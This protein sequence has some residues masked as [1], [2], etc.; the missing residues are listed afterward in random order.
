MNVDMA[1]KH[2]NDLY[3]VKNAN[4]SSSVKHGPCIKLDRQLIDQ[5]LNGGGIVFS[6]SSYTVGIKGPSF[7]LHTVCK[8]TPMLVR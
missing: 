8:H 2:W 4:N 1:P 6:V 3:L 7:A 5:I